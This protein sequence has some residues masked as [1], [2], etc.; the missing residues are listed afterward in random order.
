MQPPSTIGQLVSLVL[1]VLPGLTY[2][3]LRERW[4]GPVA[5]EAQ[6]GERILRAITASVA[7]NGAYAVVA[8]PALA[9]AWRKAGKSGFAA[10]VAEHPRAVGLW[11]LLL[12]LGVPAVAAAAVSYRERRSARSVYLPVPTAWD[13]AFGGRTHTGPRY[14]RARMKD[15]TW[16]GGWYGSRSYASGHPQEPDLYLQWSYRMSADGSFGPRVEGT[17]GVYLRM[18]DVDILEMVGPVDVRPEGDQDDSSG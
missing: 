17:E 10:L 5:G 1:L 12:F 9:S 11:A 6:L 15:G 3:F 4:R 7:L 16:V 8:G 13:Y 14:V 18:A 2:Q